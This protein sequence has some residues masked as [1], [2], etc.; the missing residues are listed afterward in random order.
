MILD[1]QSHLHPNDPA[2]EVG[3]LAASGLAAYGVV[4]FCRWFLSGPV[5]PDPWSAEVAAEIADESATPICQHCLEPHAA[6]IDFCPK[7]GGSV[8]TY[9]SL[10][11]LNYLYS[12]GYTLR[13]GTSG[14]FKHS[15]LI[16][17]G[18]LLFSLGVGFFPLGL[19]Y[20]AVFLINLARDPEAPPAEDSMA[21]GP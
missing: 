3:L 8:G 13:L 10:V 2:M 12:I 15:P 1:T 11:P 20:W 21:E 5:K 7:C 14:K 6:G 17:F 4:T 9:T 19:I 18:F 16:V